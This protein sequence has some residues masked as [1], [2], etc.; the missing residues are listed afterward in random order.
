M[1]PTP[2]DAWVLARLMADL[3][4]T[5]AELA[6]MSDAFRPLAELLAATPFP[7]RGR[8]LDVFL[9]G[10]TDRD[11]IIKAMADAD[12][13]GPPP[14]AGSAPPPSDWPPLRLEELPPVEPFPV[15]VLPEPAARLVIEG[16]D[17][18]GCPR[19]F[20][21]VPMLAVAAGTIGRSA[22]LMLKPGYFAGPTLYAACI[23]PPSDGKTPALKAVAAA[24]RA[25]ID[26][27]LAAEHAQAMERWKA[28]STSRPRPE[29]DASRR[30][31]PSPAGSTSTMRR[32]KSCPSSWRT[33]RGD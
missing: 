33:T 14:A 20:L 6:V 18:I 21:G 3:P 32:W 23:G 24:V 8:I 27:E 5:A 7:D 10:R 12:P 22:S 4:V 25:I 13:T 2:Y 28:E 9:T 29:G 30:P 19:D 31:R 15:D 1:I 17:A 11:A 26:D 16:A